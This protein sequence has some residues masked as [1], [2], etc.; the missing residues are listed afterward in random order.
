[1]MT[2]IV[3]LALVAGAA[4]SELRRRDFLRAEEAQFQ[5][6]QAYYENGS[7]LPSRLLRASERYTLAKIA[8][9]WSRSGRLAALDSHLRFARAVS[10]R[11]MRKA[12]NTLCFGGVIVRDCQEAVNEAERFVAQ[13]IRHQ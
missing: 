4:R 2:G 12:E 5:R 8:Y 10:V 9:C 1:M 3:V 11:E 7:L 6:Q 13:E